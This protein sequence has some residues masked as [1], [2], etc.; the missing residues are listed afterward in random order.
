MIY[1]QTLNYQCEAKKSLCVF[2]LILMFVLMFFLLIIIMNNLLDGCVR[3]ACWY[4]FLG[5]KLFYKTGDNFDS[6]SIHFILAALFRFICQTVTRSSYNWK[7]IYAWNKQGDIT[8]LWVMHLFLRHIVLS[9]DI[10]VI[11]LEYTFP[12]SIYFVSNLT[13]KSF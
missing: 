4:V 9:V 2:F 12:I 13:A 1:K 5:M 6:P 3:L 7:V 11:V 8:S 10:K